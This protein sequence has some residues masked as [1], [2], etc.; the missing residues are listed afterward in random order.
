MIDYSVQG[1]C[2]PGVCCRGAR[3]GH[4]GQSEGEAQSTWSRHT[5][6]RRDIYKHLRVLRIESNSQPWQY[7]TPM[8]LQNYI[9]VKLTFQMR[10]NT[11]FNLIH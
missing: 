2:K 8:L 11:Q 1:D 10:S 7:K 3:G 6:T 4:C 5:C 9:Y